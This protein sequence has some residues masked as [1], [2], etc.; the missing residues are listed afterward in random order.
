MAANSSNVAVVMV[1]FP[2]Y[3]HQTPFLHLS[4]L[5]SSYDIPVHYFSI[6]ARNQELKRRLQGSNLDQF[7]N[8]QFHD[9][10]IPST[11]A[12]KE[13]EEEEEEE[14]EDDY[15]SYFASL[16][17]LGE[18]LCSIC[19]ELLNT[20]KRVV[21]IHDSIML[22]VVQGVISITNVETY[23]FHVISAF[24]VCSLF[25]QV[26]GSAENY[27]LFLPLQPHIP[28][29]QSC[30]PPEMLEF[31]E[32][33]RDWTFKSGEI[34]N[35]CRDIE[36][37]YLDALAKQSEKPLWGLGPLINPVYL[38]NDEYSASPK[39]VSHRCI[40]WL[41]KQP[42]NS[43]IYVSFG[44]A[45]TFSLEQIIELAL[46]L[47]RSEQK[48]IWVLREADKKGN[49]FTTD[50]PKIELPIGFE[51][52]VAERGI[53]ARDFVPQMEILAHPSTGGYLFHSGWNSFLE[54]LIMGVPM[55]TWPIHSDNPFNDVLITKVLKVGLVVKDW[56]H[57]DELVRANTIENGVRDLMTST[58]GEEMRQRAI[59]LSQ[60]IKMSVKDGGATKKQTESFIAHI[61]R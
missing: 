9:L 3:G 6:G 2:E 34:F 8:I 24:T 53:I 30:Y 61:A 57:R 10:S 11:K 20:C 25:Q 39:I 38:Q 21:I 27:D 31:I 18:P 1:P 56:E 42:K 60:A 43:V 26:S 46:G 33:L 37:L 13:A 47:E 16:E 55:A 22:S 23:I 58:E 41:D 51:D 29:F 15:M 52:R 17:L 14:D 12:E 32:M 59:E 5:I 35:T 19:H 28:S 40:E 50:V 4:R 36:G 44:T 54:S 49:D 7:P 48:F 45:R